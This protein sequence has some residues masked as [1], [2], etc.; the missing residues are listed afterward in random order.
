VETDRGE[1]EDG[2]SDVNSEAKVPSR[3]VS[4][5]EANLLRILRFLLRW[6]R[7]APVRDLVTS[8][9]TRP[10]CLSRACVELVQ[11]YLAKGVVA[12]LT[13]LGGWRRQRFL[14]D[15]KVA[16]GRLWDRT[17]PQE[18]GLTF[19]RHS[20]E[21][22][23][24]IT[25]E[26]LRDK[27]A[28]P[29][30]P[31]ENELTV[32]D[33]FLLYL[34]YRVLRDERGASLLPPRSPFVTHG[35]CRLAYPE[36]FIKGP[37][38]CRLATF[39]PWVTGVGACILEALEGELGVRFLVIECEKGNIQDWKYM[40]ALGHS[41]QEVLSCFLEAVEGAGRLDLARFLLPVLTQ[42]LPEG[43]TAKTWLGGIL[44]KSGPRI[45]DRLATY[46]AAL[47]LLRQ[48]HRLRQWEQQARGVGYFD[49]GYAASQLWKAAWE[50][51]EGDTLLGR[52]QEVLR[53]ME[54]L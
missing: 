39:A 42:L 17:P 4:R 51:W 48:V 24:W 27:E 9:D 5:F 35:L 7:S 37:V 38:R 52:A 36:E 6:G 21:F 13:R 2:R 47:T 41:Q 14:R 43:A 3:M 31:P 30:N 22:L 16:E 50:Q 11:D 8:E 44:N 19:S 54:P 18:L 23:I 40:Q 53:A 28:V 46:G 26:N 29:W 20:L 34:A 32:G 1:I 10:P 33:L 12:L 15:G 49:E 45:A 25:A